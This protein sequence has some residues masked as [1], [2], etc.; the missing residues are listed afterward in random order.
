LTTINN[1][2]TNGGMTEVQ[3]ETIRQWCIVAGQAGGNKKSLL[4]IDASL[5]VINDNEFDTLVGHKLDI[6]L[7][8]RQASMTAALVPGPNTLPDYVQMSRLLAYA[9]GQGMMH[10][11]QAVTPQAVVGALLPG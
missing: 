3:R 11:T 10:F 6:V 1:V 8:P 4:G 9:V 7:G 5:V 2:I